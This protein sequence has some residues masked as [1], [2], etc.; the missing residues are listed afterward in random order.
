MDNDCGGFFGANANASK[1]GPAAAGGKLAQAIADGSVGEETWSPALANLIRVQLRLG[2]FDPDSAQPY[3]HP[4]RPIVA[5][6]NL[7]KGTPPCTS[8]HSQGQQP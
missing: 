6:G 7:C 2:M 8:P 1:N 3:A 4:S 5:M